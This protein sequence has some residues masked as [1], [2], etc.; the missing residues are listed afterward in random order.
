MLIE[1]RL[2]KLPIIDGENNILG[3]VTEKNLHKIIQSKTLNIN[4]Q[5]D[6]V[7]GAAIGCKGDYLERAEQLVNSSVD[8]LFIDV[9][10]GH[11]QLSLRA[12]E[13]LV[14]LY[15]NIDIIGGNVAT[16]EGARQ[17]IKSG[18]KAIRCGIGNG[19]ICTT[20][21][22]S[23]CGLPQATALMSMAKYCGDHDIPLIADGGLKNSGMM[24]KALAL[25]ASTLM[26]GRLLAGTDASPGIPLLKNGKLVKMHRGMAG[27]G[28]NLARA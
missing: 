5:G 12:C 22:V 23:G 28:A 26:L 16:E 21:I 25:G 27:F 7:V 15:P 14:S 18:S 1:K 9:A 8:C 6:I 24:C 11:N 3:L 19:S 20:R 2:Q 10:N 4:K 13:E 17:M